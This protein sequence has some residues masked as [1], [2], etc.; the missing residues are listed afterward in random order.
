MTFLY[1]L[2]GCNHVDTVRE[3]RD[4]GWYWVCQSCGDSGLINPRD[5]DVPKATGRYDER[6]AVAAKARA[7]K[8]V[9]QRRAAAARRTESI[10]TAK[11]RSTSTNVLPIRRAQ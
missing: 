10:A 5:R 7:E 9:V 1:R 4:D 3:H 11:A 2:F 8:T 6:K